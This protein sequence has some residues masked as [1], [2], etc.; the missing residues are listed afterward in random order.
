MDLTLLLLFVVV[1]ELHLCSRTEARAS[2]KRNSSD[3]LRA[4]N[5]IAEAISNDSQVFFPR[6]RVVLLFVIPDLMSIKLRLSTCS[7]FHTRLLRVPRRLLAQWSQARP[8]T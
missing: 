6:E 7:T 8:R 3:L 1:L 5:K 2:E 4:C